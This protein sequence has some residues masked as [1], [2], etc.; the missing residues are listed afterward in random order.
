MVPADEKEL[1]KFEKILGCV[2]PQD[3]RAFLLKVNGGRPECNPPAGFANPDGIRLRLG[4]LSNFGI[5][6]KVAILP[7]S[8]KNLRAAVPPYL[9]PFA[10]VGANFDHYPPGHYPDKHPDYFGLFLG[11]SDAIRGQ[12]FRISSKKFG[13]DA[14]SNEAEFVKASGVFKVAS[15]FTE[16]IGLLD[17]EGNTGPAANL[18]AA[19]PVTKPASESK[20]DLEEVPKS[21]SLRFYQSAIEI[22]DT[23]DKIWRYL[24]SRILADGQTRKESVVEMLSTLPPALRNYYLVRNFDTEVANQGLEA[25]LMLGEDEGDLFPLKTAKAYQALGAEKHAALIRKLLPVAQNQWK[26]IREAEEKG[27]DYAEDTAFWLEQDEKWITANQQEA[28][29]ETIWKDIQA[30]PMR[31]KHGRA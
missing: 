29:Y 22:S 14:T 26:L 2:L 4:Y 1:L 3:Y 25:C 21:L 11:L 15:S 16:F 19:I 17:L 9:L 31:Y 18:E 30:N 24:S 28:V 12:V 8:W 13:A 6:N 5:K 7:G 20:G 27:E 10:Q 23:L